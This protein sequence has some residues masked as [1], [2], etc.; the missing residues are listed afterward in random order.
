MNT[1][2]PEK[3]TLVNVIAWMTLASGIVNLF[4]GFGLSLTVLATIVGVVCTPFTVLPTILGVFEIIYAAKLISNP[5]QTVQPSTNIAIFQILCVLF[6]NVF[7]VVVGILALV[8]YNDLAVRDYFARLNGLPPIVPVTPVPP[9]PPIP[10]VVP[11]PP[12]TPESIID[13]HLETPI[14]PE[15]IDPLPDEAPDKPKRPRKVVK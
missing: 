10:P 7:S 8:F 11:T 4:W 15:E 2:Y 14:A 9:V 12:V 13:E 6:G 1:Q 5:P 3:P